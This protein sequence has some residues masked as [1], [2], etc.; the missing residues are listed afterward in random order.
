MLWSLVKFLFFLALVVLLALVAQRLLEVEGGVQVAIGGIEFSLG[1]LQSVVAAI[2]LVLVVWLIFK[3]LSLLVAVVRFL[4]GD[5]TALTRWWDR[6]RERKGYDALSNGLLALATGEGKL[7]M[8]EADRAERY[9]RRPEVTDLVKAQAAEMVGDR[10]RA[11]EAYKRMLGDDRTR[12]VGVRGLMLQKLHAGDTDTALKLAEKAFSLKP[13]HGE[14]QDVLLRLQADH[15]DWSGARRTL[16]AKLKHGALPRDVYK[17]RDAVL[18]LSEAK[19]VFAEDRTIEARE[20][21]IE[22]NRLSPDLIPAAA[23]AARAYIAQDKPRY[24]AR[25]LKKAW[26]VHPHPELAAAFAEIR[27]NETPANR[28]KR[29][30][31]LTRVHPDH[32]ETRLLLA[33]L[34]VA[35]EDFPAARRALGDLAQKHPTAR[36]LTLMAAIERGEGAS[37]A[38]VRG[39]LARALTARRGPQWVC[40]NCHNIMA[41]WAPVCDN[42]GGFDTLS[43]REPAEGEFAAPGGSEMLPLLVDP[44][45]PPGAGPVMPPAEGAATPVEGLPVPSDAGPR[46]DADHP[47]RSLDPSGNPPPPDV[48][49]IERSGTRR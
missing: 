10:K 17:R 14:T 34:H 36:A 37:E 45:A 7:A 33:E 19:E 40:D 20:A 32:P 26:S 18:A 21:A 46:R 16:G 38:V 13:K 47:D 39:W 1:P 6:K 24:A 9:L 22:A 12:F 48:E 8:A 41:T 2:L 3:I 49:P 11:E 31:E 28:V 27:P 4:D 15:H 29:F 35:A 30:A 23:M 43:W 5:D 44:P 42:C 25:V